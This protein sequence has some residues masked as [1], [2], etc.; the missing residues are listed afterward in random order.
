MIWWEL[1]RFSVIVDGV[2][3]LGCGVMGVRL[4]DV[5]V[6]VLELGSFFS[7]CFYL[8]LQPWTKYLTNCLV[9]I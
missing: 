1:L 7:G 5:G 2:V 9:F 6:T 4:V 3:G 8:E